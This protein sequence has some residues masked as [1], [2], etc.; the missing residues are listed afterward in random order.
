MENK[1]LDKNIYLEKRQIWGDHRI[2]PLFE[3]LDIRAVAVG[4]F[5]I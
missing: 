4:T 5:C 3:G 2:E 1:Q